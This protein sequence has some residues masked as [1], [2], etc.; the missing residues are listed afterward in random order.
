MQRRSQGPPTY[1]L[2]HEL[3]RTLRQVRRLFNEDNR[4]FGSILDCDSDSSPFAS[5]ATTD[6]AEHEQEDDLSLFREF[7]NPEGY[8]LTGGILLPITETNFTIHPQYTRMVQSEQFSGSPSE[9]PIEHLDRFLELCAMIQTNQ[10]SQD[11]IRMHLFRQSLTGRAKKWLKYVKPNSLTTWKE[12]VKAFL[13]RFISEEKTAEMRRK[14]ASFEQ[15]SDETLGE[16]WERFKELVQACPHHEYN[17]SLLMR[18]FYDG[19]EPMSRANLD[20]GAGGQLIKIP[21][22]Q[23]EATIEEVPK[24]YSWGG[25]RKPQAKKGGR[26]ELE[27]VD[28]HQHQIELLNKGLQKLNAGGNAGSSSSQVNAFSCEICGGLNHDTS[29][30]GGLSPKHINAYNTRQD[31]YRGNNSGLAWRQPPPGFNNKPQ[32]HV[33]PPFNPQPPNP[34]QNQNRR[35][36]YQIPYQNQS[37]YQ[38]QTQ[39]PQKH[40]EQTQS[41]PDSTQT[42]ILQQLQAMNQQIQELKAHNKIVD[43]QLAQVAENSSLNSS[44]KLPRQSNTNPSHNLKQPDTCK[45]ITLRSGASYEGPKGSEEVEKEGEDK[46]GDEEVNFE[47]EVG[48]KKSK[49]KDPID[50]R[51]YENPVPYPERVA[52]RKL[53]DKFAKFLDVMKGLHIKLP[54]HEVVTQMPSYAKFL[55]DILSNKRKLKDEFITLPHQVSALVQHKMP[56]KQRD[57]ESFTLSVKIGNLE[58]KGALADLK[59]SVSLIP[60]SISQQLNIEMI[61]T[62]KTIQLAD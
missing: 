45:A 44:S 17:Q 23:V 57:P 58:A 2:D 62:R 54:F 5:E 4:G 13:K 28:Q 24:N 29:Y 25:R 26:Y 61:P 33:E 36:Y 39:Y 56:K 41:Q 48:D 50:T 59:A 3:E 15:D 1:P 31:G 30:C 38:N 11:Y 16:A 7:G 34:P 18:F 10:V 55:K 14:I 35:G 51:K 60:L 9:D 32:Q 22:N 37:N 6:M 42:Q 47:K 8:E 43:S 46:K 19:L 52:K 27:K 49:G 40:Q 53:N 12:V 21:Q 20:A